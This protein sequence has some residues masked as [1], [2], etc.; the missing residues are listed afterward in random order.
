MNE[1]II[2]TA[3]TIE[4]GLHLLREAMEKGLITMAEYQKASK[5]YQEI[6]A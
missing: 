6:A 1:E 2:R 3:V 5:I 4:V